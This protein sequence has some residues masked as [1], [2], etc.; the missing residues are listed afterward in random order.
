MAEQKDN[1][2]NSIDDAYNDI[3]RQRAEI[4][5]SHPNSP[6]GD[7]FD[8]DPSANNQQPDNGGG[9]DFSSDYGSDEAS[10]GASPEEQEEAEAENERMDQEN[11]SDDDSN[12]GD[13]DDGLDDGG[14]DY[15]PD[16]NE[17]TRARED[18]RENI[19]GD[20]AEDEPQGASAEEQEEAEAENAK[21]G[22]KSSDKKGKSGEGAEDTAESSAKNAAATELTDEAAEATG[23]ALEGGAVDV[24]AEG[25]ADV[26]GPEVAIPVAAAEVVSRKVF[27][28]S[29]GKLVMMLLISIPL[30]AI[31][32]FLAAG[33]GL[34]SFTA[35]ADP[36]DPGT[37]T[38]GASIVS[39]AKTQIKKP[40]VWAGICTNPGPPEGCANFDCSGLTYWAVYWGTDKK[41]SL[42]H[43][44]KEQC[45]NGGSAPA[46]G[47]KVTKEE[48]KPGDLV[49]F[50][51][52][53]HHVGI[54]VGDGDFI[55]APTAHG[56]EPWVRINSLSE[57][58]DFVTGI[59][60]DA[61]K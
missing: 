22:G 49:C 58:D 37:G 61:T 4:A 30:A 3:Q 32:L 59:R 23:E 51:T 45:G 13:Y 12:Y 38:V 53:I 41:V 2:S 21:R 52:P 60:I 14:E 5:K 35:T 46:N 25:I 44:S 24:A 42:P 34:T 57:R 56:S 40:Y 54:F 31:G 28:M 27:H 20:E 29:L 16:R 55:H 36:L 47:K 39:A 19:R 10:A 33:L 9:S 11:D 8:G 17:E 18:E 50:G 26:L 15:S 48:L 1:T 43:S 6:M 7:I